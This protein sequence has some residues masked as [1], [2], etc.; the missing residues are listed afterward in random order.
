MWEDS[1]R[2]GDMFFHA[3]MESPV[4]LLEAAL[5]EISNKSMALDIYVWLAYLLP[6]LQAARAVSWKDPPR[7]S[8]PGFETERAFRRHSIEQRK[9]A[10]A[11]CSESRVSVTDDGV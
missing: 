11:V 5:R 1:V 8:G 7:Q 9:P 10:V 6:T 4:P 2:L 3:L